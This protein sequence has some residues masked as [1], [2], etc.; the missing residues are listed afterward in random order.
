MSNLNKEIRTATKWSTLTEVAAKLVTP[1][2]TMVL[3]RI[4]NPEAFG[5]LVTAT[6]II[7]FA[8]IFTDA[9]FQKYIIQHQFDSEAEK[10]SYVNVAFWSNFVM[11]VLIWGVIVVFSEDLATLL[12]N[13]GHGNVISISCFCIPLAAFSSIQMSL[14][15]KS[16]NFKTLFKVR[17]VGIMIPI[18]V[19]IPL[20]FITRSYWALITGI[21][22]LHVSNAILLTVNSDW[23]P[24]WQ[25]SFK[26][27]RKMLSFS[28]WSMIETLVIWLGGHIDL[29]VIGTLLSQHYLGIYRTSMTSVNQMMAIITAATTPILFSSLSRLQNNKEEFDMLFFK[30]Q[31]II[32]LLV[33]PTGVCIFIFRDFITNIL[34]GSQW[35]EGAYFLGLWGLTSSVTIVLSH[36]SSEVYR[37][38]GKPQLSVLSHVLHI[39]FV[40]PVVL[41]AINYSFD[42]L[43]TAKSLARLQGI[44]VNLIIMSVCI[45]MSA[46]SLLKNVLPAIVA[47][48][49]ML[50]VL[51]LPETTN[52]ALTIMY[53]VIAIGIYLS[54][55][56]LFNKERKILFNFRQIITKRKL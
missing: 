45:K 4:L 36:Y 17:I 44:I 22:A 38:K 8:E 16:L 27:L 13:K 43:C 3:A 52:V 29:F 7:S 18:V 42:F 19:T 47:S 53:M 33:I 34:L 23:K 6:M 11:S 14:F 15:K 49:S 5:V 21:I 55:I 9:G 10:K 25:Y 32:S 31:K 37:A 26:K 54:I 56:C 1:I 39:A 40:I 2:T 30:F 28:I 51:L 24:Q 35:A 50:A 48:I 20:A 12:G 41:W 46:L